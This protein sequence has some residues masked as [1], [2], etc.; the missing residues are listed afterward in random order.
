[1]MK[2]NIFTWYW[3]WQGPLWDLNETYVSG[4]C[5]LCD[6][7]VP[8]SACEYCTCKTLTRTHTNIRQQ[9]VYPHLLKY[10][11]IGCWIWNFL[12]PFPKES[13]VEKTPTL[14]IR[15]S[16]QKYS[17][18]VFEI[19]P[20]PLPPILGVHWKFSGWL[21]SIHAYLNLLDQI[22]GSQP[23]LILPP[24]ARSWPPLKHRWVTQIIG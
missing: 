18:I 8:A 24:L 20:Y 12:F 5:H 10:L 22:K 2:T 7:N 21:L 16:S 4:T 19:P 14:S 3:W 17:K 23:T 1:M 6:P 9:T 13:F 11:K 15:K